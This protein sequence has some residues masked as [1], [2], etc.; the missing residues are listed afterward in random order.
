L[1]GPYDGIVMDADSD[2]PLAG[3]LV[4]GTWAFERGIGFQAPLSAEE[5]VVETG[6]DGR[7][8]IPRLAELPGGPSTRGR[9]VPLGGCH[10]AHARRLPPRL[11][12]VAERPPL[13]RARAPAR[14]Q[15][16]RQPRAA[17]QVAAHLPARRAPGVPG[18]RI[19][20][21]RRGGVGDAGRRARARGGA[22]RAGQ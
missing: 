5:V 9:R 22:P 12:R 15:P 14:L 4:A 11:R 2:R 18:G 8:V 1:L 13:P 19:Q 6:A 7:Y 21:P 16:A 3:A 20:D 17:R 10:R